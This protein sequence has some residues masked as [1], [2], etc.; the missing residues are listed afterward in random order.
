MYIVGLVLLFSVLA[1][2]IPI[3]QTAGNLLNVSTIP[4][5]TF[6]ASTGIVWIAIMA[7]V[8]IVV[9]KQALSKSK[10]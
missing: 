6:F 7:G 10:K 9:I 2:L 8:L 4:F 3:G 5:G 1:T